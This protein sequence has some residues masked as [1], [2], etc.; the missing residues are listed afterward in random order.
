LR[1]EPDRQ[2]DLPKGLDALDRHDAMNC[3][4]LGRS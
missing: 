4:V 2:V 3:V 1:A